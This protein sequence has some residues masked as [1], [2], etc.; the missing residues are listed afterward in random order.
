[1]HQ[2]VIS[3]VIPAYNEEKTIGNV[4]SK[5]ISV[6]G[7]LEMPYEILVVDDGSTDKTRQIATRYKATVLSNGKNRGKGYTLRKGFQ[8]A[9]GDIIIT[10][11]ADGAHKPKEILGLIQPLFNGVDIAA[12]SRFLGPRKDS[13][14]RLNRLGNILFNIL[15]MI[16]TGKLITD[17]QT[18]FRAFKKYALQSLDLQSHGYEIETELTVKGLKNGFVVQEVPIC[19]EK[20]QNGKSKIRILFDGF[21]ILRTILKA[22][23]SYRNNKTS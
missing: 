6:M 22:N 17:S 3:V 10:V 21:R 2:S 12:G 5:T 20:R 7:S 19:C 11:D 13:T 18:G 1:M 4:I 8:H 14:S 23:F 9:Q 15:I 16:L